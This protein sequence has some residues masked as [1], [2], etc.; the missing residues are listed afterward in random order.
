MQPTPTRIAPRALAPAAIGTVQSSIL[1]LKLPLLA[2]LLALLSTLDA[3]LSA[4]PLGTAFTYQ[5]RL[6][7]TGQAA[8]GIDDWRL[9][10]YDAVADGVYAGGQ[11]GVASGGVVL[12][13]KANNSALLN[14]GDVRP[15]ATVLGDSWQE[16]DR[17]E[18]PGASYNPAANTWTPLPAV[19]APLLAGTG[20][21]KYASPQTLNTPN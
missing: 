12:S 18:P 9:A 20:A 11:S 3:R 1:G 8:N 4:A 7:D 10:V 19:A 2:A 13:E 5:G 16:P 21:M 14:A 15:G 6:A 17:G